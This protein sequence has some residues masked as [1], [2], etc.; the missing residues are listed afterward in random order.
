M[1]YSGAGVYGLYNVMENRIYI[2]ESANIEKRFCEHRRNFA[3]KSTVNP[4]YQE[5]VENFAFL[6]LCEM[7]TE[8][9]AKAGGFIE[10]LFIAKALR[11]RMGIYNQNKV[12]ADITG[13]ALFYFNIW[14]AIDNAIREEVGQPPWVLRMMSEKSREQVVKSLSA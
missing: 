14:D 8:E 2:G 11:E 1:A 5:P 4:M 6:V 7:S 13:E 3:S 9:H 10:S 12:K